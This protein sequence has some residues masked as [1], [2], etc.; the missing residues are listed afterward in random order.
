MT[1]RP[2]DQE[3]SP[4]VA[5]HIAWSRKEKPNVALV[6]QS[7]ERKGDISPDNAGRGRMRKRTGWI[8]QQCRNG[9]NGMQECG[10]RYNNTIAPPDGALVRI[11]F[12]MRSSKEKPAD[13][14]GF[15]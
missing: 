7:L 15:S 8:D 9:V 10:E 2:A 1:V 6:R 14:A 13:L 5:Q 11:R 3:P 12:I 4:W